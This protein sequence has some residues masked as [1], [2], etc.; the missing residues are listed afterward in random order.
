MNQFVVAYHCHRVPGLVGLQQSHTAP[1]QVLARQ[2]L[3]RPLVA[4]GRFGDSVAVTAQA[5]RILPHGQSQVLRVGTA[6]DDDRMTHL[7]GETLWFGYF[8]LSFL[9]FGCSFILLLWHTNTVRVWAKDRRQGLKY[10]KPGFLRRLL[11]VFINFVVGL[12]FWR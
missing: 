12:C 5:P 1:L 10:G 7:F 9:L 2:F 4:G 6:M 8:C 3:E 11:F